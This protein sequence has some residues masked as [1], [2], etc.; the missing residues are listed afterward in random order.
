M[1]H[2]KLSDDT[3]VHNLG[4]ESFGGGANIVAVDALDGKVTRIRPLH[5]DRDYTKEE[6]NYWRLPGRNGT[7]FE[8]GMKSYTPPF[9]LVYKCRTYSPNRIPFP[10][11]RV[12]WD[13]EGER[14]PQT[15]GE[16]KYERIS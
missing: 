7:V 6:L 3:A 13:P 16:S 4:L 8:P 9:P 2:V 1:T 14:N 11:K 10:M 5:F 15:R 12:D